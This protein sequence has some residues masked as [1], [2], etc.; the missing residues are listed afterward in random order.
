[1][2]GN[3]KELKEA[4]RFLEAFG[5]DDDESVDAVRRCSNM[6]REAKG[7]GKIG[8]YLL[9]GNTSGEIEGEEMRTTVE[10]CAQLS[11]GGA[12][13]PYE[14]M[15]FDGRSLRISVGV[16]DDARKLPETVRRALRAME[17]L[18]PLGNRCVMLHVSHGHI[19]PV[20]PLPE[21][22]EGERWRPGCYAEIGGADD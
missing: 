12:V 22:V 15:P 13:G 8:G 5:I 11:C 6:L 4:K 7:N 18:K 10:F 3:G 20:A 16:R 9:Y 21:D 14:G 2:R 19:R 17:E 1:M